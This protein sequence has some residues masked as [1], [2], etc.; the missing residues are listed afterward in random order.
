MSHG[1]PSGA[2]DRA[3]S[4]HSPAAVGLIAAMAVGSAAMWVGLPIALVYAASKLS[5]S[6]QPTM[7][8]L[9]L[10][11]LGLPLGMW[12]IAKGL[13]A[14]DRTYG[15]VTGA[16][17]RGP[18]RASWLKSMRGERESTHRQ[19]VLD[20]VMIVSVLVCVALLAVWFLLFA[21]SSLPS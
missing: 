17:A 7:G 13:G 19:S 18:E 4:P 3:R 12:L 5:S 2:P 9:L 20:V 14:L 10:V 11:L 8:P 6:S 21:G 15:R 1:V 16:V